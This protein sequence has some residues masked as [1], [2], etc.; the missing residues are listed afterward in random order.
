M[1][2]SEF[3]VYTRRD[4][5]IVSGTGARVKDSRGREY[6]DC[7]GGIGV[8]SLGHGNRILAH[9]LKKQA[10]KI[11][12]VSNHF[13]NDKRTELAE[14]LTGLAPD[15]LN[16]VFF[17]NSG[18][19]SIE[20]A[21][22]FARYATKKHGFVCAER[23]FHGRT[24]GALSATF[25]EKYREPFKPLVP[26]FDFAEYNNFE[27]FKSKINQDT[28]AVIIELV[29]GEGGIYPADK[30]FIKNLSM[31]CRENNILII[32][33]EVQTGVGRTGT[34]FTFEQY[35]IVPDIVTLAKGLGG[36]VPIGAVLVSDKIPGMPGRHGSTFGGNPFSCAAAVT[37][38]DYIKKESLIKKV[39][40]K[41]D[42]FVSLIKKNTLSSVKEIR[43]LGLMV[44][45]ELFCDASEA[46]NKMQEM[47][48]LAITAG[49]NTIRFLP[50]LVIEYADLEKVAQVLTEVLRY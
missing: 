39:S 46:V 5:E 49:E 7:I 19:E 33:D 24:M 10:E 21:I 14:K 8:A 30:T 26:G 15:S 32:I 47:G 42:R 1:K 37:V 11:I 17:C 12:S 4:I 3:E 9:A 29:Q 50:P 45:V 22:K 40:E 16:R 18:T 23:S 35:G 20:A 38:I 13:Y 36:G 28:A 41:G 27:S 6:I 2:S 43:H 34:F 31:F 25:K 44:G 48:V